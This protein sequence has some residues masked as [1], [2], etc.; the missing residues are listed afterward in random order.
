M[1]ILKGNRSRYRIITLVNGLTPLIIIITNIFLLDLIDSGFFNFDITGLLSIFYFICGWTELLVLST[2]VSI[3]PN[4][5]TW[6]IFGLVFVGSI[7]T[8]TFF[9]NGLIFLGGFCSIFGAFISSEDQNSKGRFFWLIAGILTF[10]LGILA[11]IAFLGTR[12]VDSEKS[13]RERVFTEIRKNKLPYM[14]IIPFVILLIFTYIIPIFRGFYITLF[15]Y[16]QGEISRAF[17]PVDYSKDP[18]LWTIHAILGGLQNQDPIFI[19]LENFFELFS[20]TTRAGAFQKALNNNIFFVI[21]FVPGT[22]IVSLLLAV[23][24]NNKLLKGEDTYTTVFYMPVVTSILVVAVIWLRVVFDPDS[25]ILTLIFQIFAPML[26]FIYSILNVVSFGIIPEN[27]VSSNINWLSDHLMESIALMG[28]WRRVGFDILII[29]AGLKS[30]PDS[31]YEAAEIDGHG[32]WSKFKNITL[33][34]LKG[35]LGVVI[36][37]EIINGWLVF[38]EL[39]G[40]NVAG[41]DMTLAIFLIYNYADPTIMTFAS[42]VGYMIFTISAFISLIER[43]ETR[44]SFKLLSISCLLS[45]LF[46]ISSNR[47]NSVPKSLGLGE[48]LAWL[49]YDL[50]FLLIALCCLIYY[51]FFIV[52]RDREIES[53]FI[54]LRNAG[55]FMLFVSIFFLLNGY[56]TFSKSGFGTTEFTQ[57]LLWENFPIFPVLLLGILPLIVGLWIHL[58]NKYKLDQIKKYLTIC[59]G[60]FVISLWTFDLFLISKILI[61]VLTVK[62]NSLMRGDIIRSIDPIVLIEAI[63]ENSNQILLGFT[64]ILTILFLIVGLELIRP[65]RYF[66][67]SFT[68]FGIFIISIG[69]FTSFISIFSFILKSYLIGV[70]LVIIG[71]A[72][73]FAHKYVPI[74]KSTESSHTIMS[75]G[76]LNLILANL[77]WLL[78]M[79][80]VALVSN[81]LITIILTGIVMLVDIVGFLIFGIGMIKH[82]YKDRVTLTIAGS[83]FVGW[84]LL[85]AVWRYLSPLYLRFPSFGVFSLNLEIWN[86]N[87]TLTIVAYNLTLW[88]IEQSVSLNLPFLGVIQIPTSIFFILNGILMILGTFFANK[89]LKGS[90]KFLLIFGVCNFLG[91]ILIGLPLFIGVKPGD[92]TDISFLL[93]ELGL[94][95]K[96]ILVPILGILTFWDIFK[97]FKGINQ[98]YSHEE[99]NTVQGGI[100]A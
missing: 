62:S 10:P 19:G 91:V 30:I 77:G 36:I 54:A 59:W 93:I 72:M 18:L 97:H 2:F 53:D 57:I 25:G 87:N 94:F 31:L 27:K 3:V 76:A 24:L 49:S 11:F 6:N 46:S 60:I 22:V 43:V 52:I 16:P 21:I 7:E 47:R 81:E 35:P 39:Y 41:S 26:E 78:L 20:H 95:I 65:Q 80:L 63:I 68:S 83:C 84:A 14:L 42:T 48:G 86:Q 82:K 100:V 32:A 69:I 99:Q 33:P 66:S 88:L 92:P 67:L 75:F 8:A 96:T 55:F 79:P 64:V 56:D 40:L 44:G 51:V 12:S 70:F 15:D 74:V 73:L 98:I 71:L 37:L 58:S 50:F 29:L 9:I 38:Q 45:V 61:D 90:S 89:V 5:P 13:L 23:L 1:T 28:I 17:T 4:V 34:M 85:A